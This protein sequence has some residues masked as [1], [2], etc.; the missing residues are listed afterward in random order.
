MLADGC[1]VRHREYLQEIVGSVAY[2][3]QTIPLNP[4]LAGTF[5]WLSAIASRYESYHFNRLELQ[6]SRETTEFLTSGKVMLGIDYDATDP[7]PANKVTIMSLDESIS[8][9]PS[10]NFVHKAKQLNLSRM[11]TQYIRRGTLATGSDIKL[12]DVGN[13]FVATQGQPNTNTQGELYVD[14]DVTFITPQLEPCYA[15]ASMVAVGGS[16]ASPF[17]TS[18]TISGAGPLEYTSGTTLTAISSG[19]F[20]ITTQITGTVLS[21]D[22]LTST[23]ATPV[24]TIVAVPNGAATTMVSAWRMRLQRGDV[25][26]YGITGTTA[27][28][29][30]MFVSAYNN[31]ST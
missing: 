10:E 2:A 7:A 8:K 1:R 15:A 13:L 25:L 16:A 5:P 22:A 27:T 21:A 23:G 20:L 31:S 9:I 26:T 3:S 17:G 14:Y 19:Q 11:K 29:M 4:G 18:L 6:Y 12:Y 30:S 24:N 28:A